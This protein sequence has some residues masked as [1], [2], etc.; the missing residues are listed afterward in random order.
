M[1][2]QFYRQRR[3]T[4]VLQIKAYSLDD[5]ASAIGGFVGLFMGYAIANIPDIVKSTI[6]YIKQNCFGSIFRFILFKTI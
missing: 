3:F 2:G 4:D 6:D 5:V 1:I